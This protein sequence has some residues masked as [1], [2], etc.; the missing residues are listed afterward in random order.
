[1]MKAVYTFFRRQY[2][3]NINFPTDP[4]Q[5]FN[6]LKKTGSEYCMTLA[7]TH[8]PGLS[9]SLNQWLFE[10]CRDNKHLIP[11]GAVHPAE[12]DLPEIVVKCLDHYDFP[13][14][15]V[16]CLVQKCRPDDERL[17]PLYEAVVERSRAIVMHAGSF[18]QPCEETLG[19]GYV[20]KLLRRYPTLNLIIAHLGLNDLPA[21]SGLMAVYNNLYLDAAFVFQN[22]IISTP[23]DD[24]LSVIMNFPD[25]I[26]YGS[27]FPFI[28]EPPQN[29]ITRIKNLGLSRDI[30]DKILYQNAGKFLDAIGR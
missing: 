16:H 30:L 22:E 14:I 18:P 25:R 1:M 5:L 9:R 23:Q 26:F 12:S 11:F 7:Y 3:W 8:K 19:I 2:G 15:K 17:F 27:D 10:F 13:G 6:L 24:I 28:L 4:V 29:G 20:E 21:Y